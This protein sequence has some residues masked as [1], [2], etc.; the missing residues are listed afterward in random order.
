MASTGYGLGQGTVQDRTQYRTR[1]STVPSMDTHW[2]RGGLRVDAHYPWD[3][4]MS[5]Y[6]TVLGRGHLYR[7]G[8][9]HIAGTTA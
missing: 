9:G 2:D 7:L 1:C 6:G 4:G 8:Y 3:G 5:H